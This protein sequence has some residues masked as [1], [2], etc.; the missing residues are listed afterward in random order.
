LKKVAAI[1]RE[2]KQAEAPFRI[3]SSLT[4]L[5]MPAVIRSDR[6]AL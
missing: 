5:A 3:A 4:F 2:A 1:A 6:A